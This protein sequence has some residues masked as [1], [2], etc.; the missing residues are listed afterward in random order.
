MSFSP[1]E[2][3]HLVMECDGEDGPPLATYQVLITRTIS[4]KLEPIMGKDDVHY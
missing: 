1:S 4:S 3:R 2:D